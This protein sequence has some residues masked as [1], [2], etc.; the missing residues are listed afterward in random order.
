MPSTAFRENLCLSW[1]LFKIESIFIFSASLPISH[2][3]T[4]PLGNTKL[5][6]IEVSSVSSSDLLIESAFLVLVCL[7]HVFQLFRH[8]FTSCPLLCHAF[9]K[10]KSLVG[11]ESY[12]I[13]LLCNDESGCLPPGQNVTRFKLRELYL[14]ERILLIKR[15]YLN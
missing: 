6:G 2:F 11:L 7:A 4:I 1:P 5:F 14:R 8:H 15:L 10:V 13:I 3:C 12:W 9:D